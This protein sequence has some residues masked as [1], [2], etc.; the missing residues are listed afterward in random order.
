MLDD[1][2]AHIERLERRTEGAPLDQELVDGEK[3][4][5]YGTAE[6]LLPL[7][8][9]GRVLRPRTD[10]PLGQEGGHHDP[11]PDRRTDREADEPPEAPQEVAPPAHQAPG[12]RTAG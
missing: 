4:I 2:A 1:L 9:V 3:V 6:A 12:T 8:G 11:G 5:A 7:L 10:T